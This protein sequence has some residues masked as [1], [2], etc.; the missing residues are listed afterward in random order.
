MLK[1]VRKARNLQEPNLK[2]PNPHVQLDLKN[3]VMPVSPLITTVINNS[4]SRMVPK[5]QNP[6]VF[7]DSYLKEPPPARRG[8]KRYW[9]DSHKLKPGRWGFSTY[10]FQDAINS[11]I[12]DFDDQGIYWS[13]SY[14]EWIP[15]NDELSD[16]VMALG[17][18]PSFRDALIQRDADFRNYRYRIL[19]RYR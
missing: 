10:S 16:P 14:E 8:F 5:N 6:I 15:I 9:I 3:V 2:E 12:F 11:E 4:S 17:I 13:H 19:Q 18:Q 7:F 1:A